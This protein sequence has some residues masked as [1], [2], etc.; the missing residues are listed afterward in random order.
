MGV[1]EPVCAEEGVGGK[2]E[3]TPPK[4]APEAAQAGPVSTDDVILATAGYDHTIKF[5]AA[6]TGVCTRTLQHPD[7]PVNSLEIAN[8]GSLLAAGGYQH[9]RMFDLTSG[10]LNPVVNYEGISKNI[11]KVGFQED[12]RWMFTGGEDCSARIWDLKMR[13]L[14]CQR[15]FQ[16]TA[17][18]TCVCLHPNQQELILGDQSGVIHIWNLQNDQSTPL[19]PEPGSSL[20]DIAIDAQGLYMAAVNNQGNCY[21]WGLEGGIGE[22]HSKLQPKN[23]ILA[24]KRYALSCKFSPDSGLLVT[25]SADKTAKVWRTGDFSLAQELSAEGQRWVWS[26]AF[27][28]DSE[29]LVTA[30]SEGMGRLW[31]I[32]E[33]TVKRKYEG[34][35]KAVTSLA[36]RDIHHLQSPQ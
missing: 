5:W 25:T 6:H 11:T 9:I 24:H 15:I 28:A 22:Q 4:Q 13:N 33:G 35:Q 34:H 1:S 26:A 27:T 31:S 8:D 36:F 19:I 18:V 12:A 32:K 20:Q 29:Y 16:A 10:N 14:S 21:V 17:P 3:G 23:K 7:S 30:S 2:D